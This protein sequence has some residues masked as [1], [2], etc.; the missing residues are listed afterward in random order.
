MQLYEAEDYIGKER[1]RTILEKI[2][3]RSEDPEGVLLGFLG[4]GVPPGCLNPDPIS[5]QKMSFSAPVF[6]R[7]IGC[8]KLL[9][10]IIREIKH[11][12]YG[13]REIQVEKFSKRELISR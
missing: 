7:G 11:R 12:V 9:Y 8:S 2:E 13:K 4:G 10:V 1:D 3:K 5:D 6:R